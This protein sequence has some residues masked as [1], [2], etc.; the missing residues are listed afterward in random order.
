MTKFSLKGYLINKPSPISNQLC[1][2][3]KNDNV[4]LIEQID[5]K[6]WKVNFGGCIGFV[7][8]PY[9]VLTDDLIKKA[10]SIENDHSVSNEFILNQPVKDFKIYGANEKESKRIAKT[11]KKAG[12]T[13]INILSAKKVWFD[14]TKVNG[15][16][17]SDQVNIEYYINKKNYF[18]SP[19]LSHVYHVTSKDGK[20]VWIV[21]YENKYGNKKVRMFNK[22]LNRIIK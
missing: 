6:W 1:K 14:F 15:G 3:K 22:S 17:G 10:K 8:S 20:W 16:I 12:Y 9:L 13:N 11:F 4:F 21:I 18:S 7:T 19:N 2:F 5:D